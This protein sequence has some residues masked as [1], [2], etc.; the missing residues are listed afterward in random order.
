MSDGQNI[1]INIAINISINIAIN[2]SINIAF[3]KKKLL[4][5]NKVSAFW[6]LAS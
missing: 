1:S 3:N 6:G 4:K 5:M 2:I